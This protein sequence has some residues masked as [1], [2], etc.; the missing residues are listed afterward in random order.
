M[1]IL[2]TLL[3][4]I[5]LSCGIAATSVQANPWVAG[6]DSS[7]SNAAAAADQAKA[8]KP[9]APYVG[10]YSGKLYDHTGKVGKAEVSFDNFKCFVVSIVGDQGLETGF[11]EAKGKELHLKHTD[12]KVYRIFTI[13]DEGTIELTSVDGKPVTQTKDCCRLSRD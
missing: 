4:V 6:G 8:E 9:K 2:K 3:P 10:H 12:G 5:A 13:V 1:S 7:G 11:V